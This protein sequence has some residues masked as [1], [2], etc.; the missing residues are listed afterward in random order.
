MMLDLSMSSSSSSS[1]TEDK[2]IGTHILELERRINRLVN[3]ML[4]QE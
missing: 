1:Y 4:L 3:G 2:E